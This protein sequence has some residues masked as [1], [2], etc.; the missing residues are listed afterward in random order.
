M[1][2]EVRRGSFPRMLSLCEAGKVHREGI[3][4]RGGEEEAVAGAGHPDVEEAGGLGG[5]GDV[6][7][8]GAD[9]DDIVKFEALAALNR[10]EGGM[11]ASRVVGSLEAA[12]VKVSMGE[13]AGLEIAGESFALP[14][15][16]EENGD[17]VWR[18]PTGCPP[19]DVVGSEPTFVFESFA[20]FK[21]RGWSAGSG[22]FGVDDGDVVIID[23]FGGFQIRAGEVAG[24]AFLAGSQRG[25]MRSEPKGWRRGSGRRIE[26]SGCWHCSRRAT[27]R[28]GRAVP[29][30]L[31]VWGK[32]FFPSWSLKRSF[33]RRAW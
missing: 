8:A 4:C 5:I 13:A 29:E 17:L 6:E 25:R 20:P 10:E 2:N 18:H 12:V 1:K 30:P 21:F 9:H 15:L 24:K 28:R 31:R 3:R 11:P 22:G 19:A 27:K 14:F 26:P 7:V 33:M 32:R 23:V 16:K